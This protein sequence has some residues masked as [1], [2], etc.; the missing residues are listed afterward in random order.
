LNNP[1]RAAADANG[2][3]RIVAI[4]LHALLHQ[5]ATPVVRQ[6]IYRVPPSNG[7]VTLSDLF[8]VGSNRLLVPERTTDK[9]FLADLS[10]ATDITPLENAAGRLISDPTKTIEQLDTAGLAAAGIVPVLKTIVVNALTSIDPLLEKIE[11]ICV[12]GNKIVLTHD[13]D[14]NVSDTA[15]IPSAPL[16]DGPFVQLELIGNNYPRFYVLPLP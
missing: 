16:P 4:N 1:N 3:A 2:N 9:I 6:Y 7:T 5:A 11:G 10:G 12:V 8:S 13:N 14:F 15:S